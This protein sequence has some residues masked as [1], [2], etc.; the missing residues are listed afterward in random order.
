V[1]RNTR[2]EMD[3]DDEADLRA[4]LDHDLNGTQTGVWLRESGVA[5]RLRLASATGTRAATGD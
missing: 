2:L 3:V 1:R 5:E 4:L